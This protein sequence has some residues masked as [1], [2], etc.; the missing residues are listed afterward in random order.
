MSLLT[1]HDGGQNFYWPA[2][3][4][5]WKPHI[6]GGT[7]R[8]FGPCGTVLDYDATLLFR[9]VEKVYTYFEPVTPAVEEA[10]LV[11][12]YIA[13]TAVGTIW[14]VTHDAKRKFDMEDKRQLESISRF[15]SAA[16][17][18]VSSFESNQ[19]LAA[20][21]ESS[22]DAIVSKD[23]NGI[24]GSWNSGAQR[25]FGYSPEE[26]VGR[27]ITL[28]IPP[29][30]QDEEK[31]II[32]RL[33]AGERI[34]HFETVRLRKDGS[35]INVSL[36]ISPVRDSQGRITGASKVAR[37]ITERKRIEQILRESELSARLLQLQDE[38]K[39][40]IARELHDGAGQLLAAIA[41]NISVIE[42][43]KGKLSPDAARR[44]A[45]NGALVRQISTDIRTMSYLLHPPLL[46]E[47]GLQSAL[48]WYV[49]GFA[50]RSGI[51]AK[52]DIAADLGRLPQDFEL[53]LFR[54]VQESL[55]NV[56]RHSK[57]SSASVKL[58][59]LGENLILEV[60]DDG[61]GVSKETLGQITSGKTSGVGLR[62]MRERIAALGG[63]LTV[64]SCGKGTTVSVTLPLG[65]NQMATSASS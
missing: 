26:A 12:F 38:E 40:R 23:L 46:D 53:C 49:G 45:E 14:A 27:A 32:E 54:I 61:H 57:G 41:M 33:R 9:H 24:I 3:A 20:I 16:F 30:L 15:A 34:D 37:D 13:G 64:E 58:S 28:I 10:L 55:T 39:R 29:E 19:L 50:E 48:K 17:Q 5:S 7:P 51:I 62:G 65:Q 1:K 35:R 11:P 31:R 43:E 6:G 2:I 21:V 59:R 63:K 8:N 47:M 60:R 52:L 22:D 36:T 25:I 4:G 18:S 44:V 42:Q 56:H